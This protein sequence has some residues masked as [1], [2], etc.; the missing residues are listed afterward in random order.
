MA[1]S[2]RPPFSY[3]RWI[4]EHR[5][6]FVFSS[7]CAMRV[8]FSYPLGQQQNF[9]VICNFAA[10][11]G[12]KPLAERAASSSMQPFTSVLVRTNPCWT[13]CTQLP[14]YGFSSCTLHFPTEVTSFKSQ[15]AEFQ[16]SSPASTTRTR[17]SPGVS[18]V[19]FQGDQARTFSS[20]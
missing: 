2:K 5:Q 10:V 1:A 9:A 8:Y 16:I 13:R 4:F 7:N 17:L 20:T 11:V 19:I 12:F 15:G 3:R 6:T 18:L 14:R